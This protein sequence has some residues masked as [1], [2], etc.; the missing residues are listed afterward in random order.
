MEVV[1]LEQGSEDGL[2][3]R[4]AQGKGRAFRQRAQH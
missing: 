3:L 1:K 4:E 2:R